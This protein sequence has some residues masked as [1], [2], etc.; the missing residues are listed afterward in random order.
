[1]MTRWRS[2]QGG[3]RGRA[4]SP[5][6]ATE[7]SALDERDER[8]RHMLDVVNELRNR[9]DDRLT[10]EKTATPESECESIYALGHFVASFSRRLR[11]AEDLGS[12]L[13]RV[14]PIERSAREHRKLGW[15][16]FWS[17]DAHVQN[18]DRLMRHA[19]RDQQPVLV[20][21]IQPAYTPEVRVTV[22]LNLHLLD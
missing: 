19:H 18:L 6:K 7:Q 11:D 14:L 5:S 9:G 13:K 3:R 4:W 10:V 2:A 8:C 21:N 16:I 1:M 17:G 15:R 12:I 20:F 22:W